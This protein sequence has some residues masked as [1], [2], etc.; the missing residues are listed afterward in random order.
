[1]KQKD[2]AILVGI[3]ALAFV[4]VMWMV[5]GNQG[6]LSSTETV[7]DEVTGEPIGA[8]EG[9]PVTYLLSL[10][11]KYDSADIATT[12]QV[13]DEQPE[14]WNNPR[15][16]F[17]DAN[18]YTEY[19]S[20]AGIVTIDDNNPATYYV[21]AT[22]SGFNTEF[23]EITIPNGV[24]LTLSDLV[25]Y[26]A[27]PSRFSY[28]MTAVGT[29]TDEDL[30]F[31]LVNDTSAEVDDDVSLDV[32]DDTEFRGWKVIVT[33]EK[34]FSLD[35]DGDGIYDEGISKFSITVGDV[36][37][38]IFDTSNSVDLF[39]SNDEYSF[40][41]ENVVLSDGDKLYV[42]AEIEAVTGDYVGANDE[43]WGEGEGVLSYIKIY[44]MDGDLFATVDVTA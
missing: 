28:K 33:D 5:I 3:V 9:R 7:V 27:N 10:S 12:V 42:D 40:N 24:G 6:N 30:A 8:W 26:E 41:I 31:T 32:A 37:K 36:T 23:F 17:D 38:T 39:D 29:T 20:V 16:D 15:G 43:A 1:M 44:N 11:N 14:D 35:V 25:D 22:A 19:T 13:Y 18:L 2:T 4:A 34:E 21:V